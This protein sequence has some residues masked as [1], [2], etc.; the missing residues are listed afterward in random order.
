M[1][2][3]ADL[4]IRRGMEAQFALR[5]QRIAAGD[6]P[7][8]WKVGFSAPAVMEKLGIQAPLVGFLM[9]SALVPDGGSISLAGWSKP[10]LEP[11]VAVHLARDVAGGADEPAIREAVAA[12]GPAFELADLFEPPEDP[13]RILSCNV[14]QRR[15]VLGPRDETRS[16]ARVEGLHARVFRNGAEVEQTA[17]VEANTGRIVALVRH[18]ADTLASL[19]ERLR[20]GEIVISGS[21]VRQLFL[22]ASDQ[23]ATFRLDPAGAVSVRFSH[24]GKG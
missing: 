23:D 24:D 6:Q 3:A 21:V 20:A 16:G 2:A 19:G 5:R 14:Y 10:V 22:G 8:G 15:L 13:E 4:R 7:L 9:V 17:N 18:V 12:I 11:E 1:S